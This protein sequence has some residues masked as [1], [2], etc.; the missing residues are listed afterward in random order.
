M[1]LISKY[2]SEILYSGYNPFSLCFVYIN[3]ILLSVYKFRNV[4]FS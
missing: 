3:V 1:G 4:L 2:D